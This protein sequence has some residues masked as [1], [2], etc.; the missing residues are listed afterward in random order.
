MC[1]T[2]GT[3]IG[4]LTSGWLIH[5][6]SNGDQG[7]L[8]TYRIIFLLYAA[9]GI[10]KLLLVIALSP[11]VELHHEETKYNE[12]GVEDEELLSR[13]SSPNDSTGEGRSEVAHNTTNGA[14]RKHTVIHPSIIQ[15]ASSLL[16]P[17]SSQSLLILLRLI[18]LF[19]LDSFASGMASPSWLTY[20]F[21]TFHGIDPGVL[22]TLFFTTNILA[23]LSN[24]AALPL[25]R[26][27]GPLKTM[28]F[29]HLPSAIFLGMIPFPSPGSVGT[30]VSMSL[31]AL[32]ACSQS[33][34]QAPRQAFLAAIMRSEERT[35]MLGI[36]NI[37]KTVAQAGGIGTSGVLAAAR[38]WRIMLGSA[39]LLKVSYDLLILWTF[40]HMAGPENARA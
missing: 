4:T 37:V 39:G 22:G 28:A 32:R 2:A 38:S 29:T 34:D 9:L 19:S 33:M 14:Q 20:F 27:L 3:A 23:T 25:A 26:R 12:I 15:R 10:L 30:P 36:V 11:N 6:L 1:G 7:D 18:A 17:M 35:A 13:P 24:F 5:T 21:T 16:P 8:K 31:L 40:L